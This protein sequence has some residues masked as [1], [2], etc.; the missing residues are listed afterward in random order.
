MA[1][2]NAPYGFQPLKSPAGNI[3]ANPYSATGT[4]FE[5]DLVTMNSDG[6]VIKLTSTTAVYACG[7]AASYIAVGTSVATLLVYD[8]PNQVF[9]AQSLLT[10]T[11][12]QT[13]IGDLYDLYVGTG[14]TSS[15]LSGAGV[16]TTESNTSSGPLLISGFDSSVDNDDAAAY[17][18]VQVKLKNHQFGS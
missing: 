14:S 12:N 7:A 17:P 4:I 3:S 18:R 5:G 2:L 6:L 16:G 15:R 13:I 9:T 11:S 8:D 10:S 1:N